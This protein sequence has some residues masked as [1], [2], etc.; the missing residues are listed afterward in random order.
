[1]V[2]AENGDMIEWLT[3]KLESKGMLGTSPH[4]YITSN[5]PSTIL[6]R[7][8]QTPDCRGGSYESSYSTSYSRAESNTLRPCWISGASICV[9]PLHL[10][11]RSLVARNGQC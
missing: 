2:H 4:T 9:K 11:Y 3:D 8:V 1:M 5:I 6:P 7:L 10:A